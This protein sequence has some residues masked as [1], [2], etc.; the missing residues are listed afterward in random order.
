MFV[1]F[2]RILYLQTAG[3]TRLYRKPSSSFET[4]RSVRQ[5]CSISSFLI[6]SAT[7]EIMEHPLGGLLNVCI[8]LAN[9]EKLSD[10]DY[11]GDVVFIRIR[12]TCTCVLDG[13]ARTVAI[14]GTF[15]V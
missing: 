9:G 1:N 6:N 8:K 2:S 4:A 11:A 14:F 12:G 15:E 13:F 5:W 10:L 7:D 3:R